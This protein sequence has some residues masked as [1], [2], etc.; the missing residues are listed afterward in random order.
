VTPAN[1]D[2]HYKKEVLGREWLFKGND[3]DMEVPDHWDNLEY[4]YYTGNEGPVSE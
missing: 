2:T 4:E 1:L 3:E